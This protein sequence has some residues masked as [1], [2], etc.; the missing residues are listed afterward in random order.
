MQC[1][2]WVLSLLVSFTCFVTWWQK[3]AELGSVGKKWRCCLYGVTWL[4]F[5]LNYNTSFSDK[6]RDDFKEMKREIRTIS[7]KLKSEMTSGEEGIDL[8]CL[9]RFYR[10]LHNRLSKSKVK[11]SD[12]GHNCM[13][14]FCCSRFYHFL[15]V[16]DALIRCDAWKEIFNSPN[17]RSS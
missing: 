4:C 11:W 14:L 9:C 6:T 2:F 3:F 5:E 10:T 1:S 15:G 13:E 7:E 12:N 16:I 8:V 17:Q